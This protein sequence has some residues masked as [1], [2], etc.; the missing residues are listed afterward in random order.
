[1]TCASDSRLKSGTLISNLF[2]IQLI[3][4]YMAFKIKLQ[5]FLPV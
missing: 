3:I 2:F 5:N 1:M 4:Y